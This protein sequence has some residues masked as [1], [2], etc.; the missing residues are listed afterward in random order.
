[1]KTAQ[2]MTLRLK[3]MLKHDKEK[4]SQPLLNMLKSDIF[5]IVNNYFELRLED[6]D[7]SYFVDADGNY[8][9]EIKLSSKRIK[10][11]NFLTV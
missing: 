3:N 7:I 11:A 1:M 8:Q 4:V 5:Q 2:K 10:K 9:F 6:M